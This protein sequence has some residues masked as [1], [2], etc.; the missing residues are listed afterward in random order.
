MVV[1]LQAS[2]AE[3]HFEPASAPRKADD[4]DYDLLLMFVRNETVAALTVPVLAIVVAGTMLTWA[5]PKQ[6]LFWLATILICEGILLALAREFKRQPREEVD[7]QLWR[8]Q[9]A[10]AEFLYGVCW[11]AIAFVKFDHADQAAY[12]FLFASLTVVTAI[13]MMFAA[14]VMQILH[15]GTVP[16]T[17]GLVLRFLLTGEAFY[18]VMAVVA[19][20]IHLYLV[21]LVEGLQRTAL[22]ML[23]YRAHKER[24]IEE[25]EHAKLISDEARQK[26]EAANFAK[27]KFLANMSHELRTPL[28]AILGFSEIIKTE[29]LGPVE[30]EAYKSYAEDIHNSGSHLL[31]VINDIL[32]LSRIEAGRYELSEETVDLNAIALES[33]RFL[34]LR[35]DTKGVRLVADLNPSMPRVWADARAI[36]QICLNLLSNAVKFT[37]A[38]GLVTLQ[39]GQTR[40]GAPFV[41][42]RDNGPGIP[43]EEMP[44]VLKSFGQGSLA[45]QLGEGGT[46]LGL[47]IVK[48]LAELHGGRFHLAS[49]LGQGTVA[50][51]ILPANRIRKGDGTGAASLFAKGSQTESRAEM[52]L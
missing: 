30:N 48:G 10:A 32:D 16:V 28:N 23:G 47:P 26:A 29:M 6:L 37:P 27:S 18:W 49:E 44:T 24:L 35:A 19:I 7:L 34:R 2:T 51:V 38:A 3:G 45:H 50:S 20:G 1:S 4:F 36:R 17:A 42:V 15:A 52:I 21:F 43:A 22:S 11:A 13:R 25:L 9:L 8:R 39:T 41:L 40:A 12:F 46:G 14:S 31:K 33:A 5:E